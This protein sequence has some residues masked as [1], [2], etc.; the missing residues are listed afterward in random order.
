MS[1]TLLEVRSLSK[2][3]HNDWGQ[4]EALKE[5]SFSCARSQ[6]IT[7]VGPSGCGKT[8]LLRIMSGLEQASSGEVYF[9]DQKIDGPGGD[10]AVVFQEPRL[11]P[12]LTVE[13]NVSFGIINKKSPVEVEST[14]EKT[15]NLVG[16]SAFRQAYPYELSGGM[17]QRVAIARA[18]AFE[19]KALLMDEPFSALD[20]QTRSRLQLELLDLWRKT[21]KTI[22]LVT[23]DID[24]ALLLSQKILIMTPSP[25]T[26]KEIL[27]VPITYPRNR[28]SLDFVNLRKYI[29]KNI[30]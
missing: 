15:L 2:I 6:F 5:I 14:V 25:G 7:I 16:L 20:A 4:V 24:E 10:R 26:I 8:T 27:E 19:P 9:E 29:L 12:W 3:F 13:Q 18:F 11:F 23:H 1:N 30:V 17:A 22:I 21:E 28:D